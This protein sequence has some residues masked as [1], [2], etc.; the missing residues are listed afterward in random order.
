M[1]KDMNTEHRYVLMNGR[2]ICRTVISILASIL[3]F[4]GQIYAEETELTLTE[5]EETEES[6][7]AQTASPEAETLENEETV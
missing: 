7:A 3:V 4:S 6:E 2:R 1:F 5:A